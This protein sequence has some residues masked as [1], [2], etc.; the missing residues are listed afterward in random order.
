MDVSWNAE[1][2]PCHRQQFDQSMSTHVHNTRAV[3]DGAAGATM[4]APLFQG[5]CAIGFAFSA[6]LVISGIRGPGA[7]TRHAYSTPLHNAHMRMHECRARVDE[8]F[9]ISSCFL[10][11]NVHFLMA[12]NVIQTMPNFS[13]LVAKIIQGCLTAASDKYVCIY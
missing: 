3:R 4:A 9:Q 7:V 11:S 12:M 8:A 1:T 13:N 5:P 6:S 10:L 2:H